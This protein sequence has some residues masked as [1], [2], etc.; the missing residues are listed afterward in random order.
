MQMLPSPLAF[1]ASAPLRYLE[2]SESLYQFDPKHQSRKDSS[3]ILGPRKDGQAAGWI[4][5]CLPESTS[6]QRGQAACRTSRNAPLA[7]ELAYSAMALAT[8]SVEAFP[9][10]PRRVRVA[11]ATGHVLE[12]NLARFNPTSSSGVVG[13]CSCDIKGRVLAAHIVGAHLAFRDDASNCGFKTRG[14]F[15]FFKPIEH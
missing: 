15:S 2:V 10:S 5:P 11:A 7:Y 13:N 3:G 14:H 8:S 1:P 4:S 9:P 6:I 12:T